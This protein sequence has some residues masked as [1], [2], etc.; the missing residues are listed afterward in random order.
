MLEICICFDD[1]YYKIGINLIKSIIS[2]TKNKDKLKFNILVDKDEFNKLNNEFITN[3]KDINYQIKEFIPSNKLINLIEKQKERYEA[4]NNKVKRPHPF[5]NYLN[6]ARYYIL[7]FF[8]ELDKIIFLDADIIFNKPIE[9]LYNNTKLDKYYFAAISTKAIFN[10]WNGCLDYPGLPEINLKDKQ[11]NAGVYITLLSK[12]K[13]N[14][15]INELE[16]LIEKNNNWF[17]DD[18]KIKFIF[19]TGT[20]PPLNLVFYNK[21]EFIKNDKIF[22]HYKGYK[23]KR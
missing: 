17:S 20:Q 22:T 12:W 4:K 8:P 6:Y 19:R 2:T 1:Y 13:E 23:S 15:I 11:F 7:E 3:F 18:N 5:Y 14:N 21:R 9:I 10:K 16:S